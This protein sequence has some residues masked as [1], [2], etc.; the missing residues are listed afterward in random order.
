[1]DYRV[2]A[3][4]LALANEISEL[5]LSEIGLLDQAAGVKGQLVHSLV[6]RHVH[7]ELYPNWPI[8]L[9]PVNEVRKA[10]QIQEASRYRNIRVNIAT[11]QHFADIMERLD[12]RALARAI[13]AKEQCDRPKFDALAMS[14]ALEIFEFDGC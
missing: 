8:Q 7:I 4:P 9:M 11:S 10:T 6:S 14:D 12:Y 3:Q 5:K 13:G 2:V 1:L